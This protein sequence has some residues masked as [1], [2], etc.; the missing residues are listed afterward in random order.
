MNPWGLARHTDPQTSHE[1]AHAIDAS[2]L[3]LIILEEIKKAAN[4]LTAEEL[5]DRLPGIALNSIT[6]RIA[7]M[8]RKGFIWAAGVRRARS[9]RNQRVL[10]WADE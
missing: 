2:R 3:E 8:T 7:Q 9:G 1:A 4:G 5:G 6:P 10:R